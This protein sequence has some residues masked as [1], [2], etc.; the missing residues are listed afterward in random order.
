[1]YACA[2]ADETHA[3][4]AY[5]VRSVRMVMRFLSAYLA[6]E[7]LREH[8]VSTRAGPSVVAL[9]AG[10]AHDHAARNCRR[11]HSVAP[12]HGRPV[13][14]QSALTSRKQLDDAAV[15]GY[16]GSVLDDLGGE[17]SRRMRVVLGSP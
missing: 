2:D 9:P 8:R 15:S 16:P 12:E 11:Y 7:A 17:D 14:R 6:T 10:S 5:A 1:M 4:A 13:M 3:F